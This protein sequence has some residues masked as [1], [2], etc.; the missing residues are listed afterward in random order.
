[1]ATDD[2]APPALTLELGSDKVPYHDFQSLV[3]AFTV[4]LQDI[5]E[6]ACGDRK[7]VRWEI[8]VSKGSLRI[9]ASLPKT[10]DANTAGRVLNAVNRPSQRL[11]GTLGKF[12]RS[13]PV[14]QLLT[15]V[16]RR[17]ILQVDQA[18]TPR[19]PSS[20]TEY[21]TVEGILDTLSARG[22]LSFIISE[23]IWNLAVQCTVPGD[24]VESMRS[25]WMQR[26]AA[27]GMVQY[28]QDGHPTSIKAE[29]VVLF[30]YSDKPIE[31]FRGLLAAD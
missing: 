18:A 30:P 20:F 27:H 5:S 28:D 9:A 22:H 8:S 31:A 16:E 13:V 12:P 26:V 14:T 25:M 19:L 1:M 10:T 29:E 11:R 17:D 23:P 21:G 4:L 24:L 15:G 2:A 6:D 3:R 7:A